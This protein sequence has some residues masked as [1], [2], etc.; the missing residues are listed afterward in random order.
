MDDRGREIDE[1]LQYPEIC[2]FLQI[3]WNEIVHKIKI[4]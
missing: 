3:N 1:H 4:F 2:L